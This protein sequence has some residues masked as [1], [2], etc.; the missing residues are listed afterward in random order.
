MVVQQTKNKV[1]LLG[2]TSLKATIFCGEYLEFLKS[3]S[4]EQPDST[5]FANMDLFQI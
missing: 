1:H 5:I 4:F 2:R 3:W